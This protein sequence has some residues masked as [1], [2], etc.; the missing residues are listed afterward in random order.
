M[1]VGFLKRCADID[2]NNM[3]TIQFCGRGSDGHVVHVNAR[4]IPKTLYLP[5][6]LSVRRYG[7]PLAEIA[8]TDAQ[9]VVGG[10]VA[11]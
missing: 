4:R 11:C 5:R 9:R 6:A 10:G 7:R 1:H 3:I 2:E 8:S